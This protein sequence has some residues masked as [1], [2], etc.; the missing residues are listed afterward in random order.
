MNH[1]LQIWNAQGSIETFSQ[2]VAPSAA[3]APCK[4]GPWS[5]WSACGCG[6]GATSTRTRNVEQPAGIGGTPC[7]NLRETE[8]CM[9]RPCPVDCKVSGWETDGIC[10]EGE[11]VY[12]KK[13]LVQ[14]AHG[15]KACPPASQLRM[16]EKCPVDCTVGD[17]YLKSACTKACGGGKETWQR[18][19][20]KPSKN[21]GKACPAMTET[22]DCNKQACPVD[23]KV[24]EWYRTATCSK[25]CGGGKETWQ[26]NVQVQPAN[27]GKACPAVTETRDCNKQACPVDCQVSGWSG[28]S[29][30]DK[31]CGGGRQTRTRTVIRNAANGGASCPALSQTQA[32]N[33]QACPVVP[34]K[35]DCQV[36]GW[37]GWSACDKTCGGG[38]QTRTRTVTRNAANGGASCPALSETQACNTQACPVVPAKVD[39]LVSGWRSW[40]ECDKPCGGGR[41]MRTKTVIRNS[42]N[43]GTPCP[44]YSTMYETQA[45]NTQACRV[46]PAKVDCQVSGWSGWS[47]CDRSCGGGRQTRTQTVTRNAANGG[48]SCP[49]LSQTQACNTQACPAPVNQSTCNSACCKVVN[50]YI[51]RGWWYTTSSFGECKGC[52][53]VSYPTKPRG[54]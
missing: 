41:Q 18:N 50:D 1:P 23:C 39:C 53:V 9:F 22:R 35:V 17:W 13:I 27:G 46:V 2:G 3:G 10:R 12:T 34:A 47:W 28:W 26:R 43:G 54:C 5:K 21:G 44:P 6:E 52:P 14:A 45:C 48:A 40:T 7:L 20:V 30:C 37:S 25:I 4:V 8:K 31:T 42:A 19:V 51:R 36:S 16:V 49:P 15:G 38:R 29:A 32:C 33:T 24:G 11:K